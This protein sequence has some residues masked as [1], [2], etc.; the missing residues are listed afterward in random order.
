M[1]I[2]GQ[3]YDPALQQ[4]CWLRPW[5]QAQPEVPDGGVPLS[6]ALEVPVLPGPGSASPTSTP[7]LD[8]SGD[9]LS[10]L[11]APGSGASVQNGSMTAARVP[12]WSWAA[13]PIRRR[14]LGWDA[15]QIQLSA[16]V[17]DRWIFVDEGLEE[18][19]PALDNRHHNLQTI[20]S[21]SRAHE[22]GVAGKPM[23]Y[24]FNWS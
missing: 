18:L 17:D 7:G 12:R 14:V 4:P 19:V 23:V 24:C 8:L 22:E 1:S 11:S 21:C 16:L 2:S 15:R 13:P 3:T 6:L 10:P 20:T 5:E 9:G